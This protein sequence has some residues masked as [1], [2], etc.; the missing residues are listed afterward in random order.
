MT[1]PHARNVGVAAGALLATFSTLICCVLPALLVSVGAGAALI[2][3]VSAVAQLIWLSERK[4]L[5]F[6]IATAAL[7]VSG[8]VLWRARRLPCPVDP[9]AARACMRL[10][11]ISHT[12]YGVAL[13]AFSLAI[14]FAFL[15]PRWMG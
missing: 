10:R 6:G 15:L 9:V 12:L 2:G 4:S 14:V 7:L 8:A 11:A 1:D 3:L 13:S 5:V